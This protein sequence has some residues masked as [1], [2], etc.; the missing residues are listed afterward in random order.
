MYRFNTSAD[1]AVQ[2]PLPVLKVKLLVENSKTFG[3]D[4][5]EIGRVSD[6]MTFQYIDIVKL[7]SRQ[8]VGSKQLVTC[9]IWDH[10]LAAVYIGRL[11]VDDLYRDLQ[12][13]RSFQHS[14]VATV[15][16]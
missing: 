13:F 14:I 4:D 5:R 9:I 10:T 11:C 1:F 2:T 12:S 16:P 7:G 3:L 6:R 8:I 15:S